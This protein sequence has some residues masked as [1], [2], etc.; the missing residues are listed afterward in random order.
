MG[1]VRSW[2]REVMESPSF[3]VFKNHEDTALRQDLGILNLSVG[4]G[5]IT[6]GGR[7]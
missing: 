4:L 6:S 5:Y 2:N 7:F 3:K 1:V